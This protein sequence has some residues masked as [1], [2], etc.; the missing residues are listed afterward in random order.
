MV[1]PFS[2]ALLWVSLAGAAGQKWPRG[3][4]GHCAVVYHSHMIIFGGSG[5][6]VCRGVRSEVQLR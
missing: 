5:Y 1:S 2:S 6:S 4:H 3:R